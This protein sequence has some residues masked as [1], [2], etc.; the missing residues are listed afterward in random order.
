MK[1]QAAVEGADR[2]GED[3]SAGS[4]GI[5]GGRA[6]ASPL[7]DT[8]AGTAFAAAQTGD[9]IRAGGVTETGG[10]AVTGDANSTTPIGET[11]GAASR[12]AANT[13]RMTNDRTCASERN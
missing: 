7:E 10:V 12:S 5:V 4:S 11:G 9:S 8:G 13:P 1:R 2:G 6:I 3:A